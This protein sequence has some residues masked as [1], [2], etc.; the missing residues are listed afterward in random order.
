[1]VFNIIGHPEKKGLLEVA[2]PL[3]ATALSSDLNSSS[4]NNSIANCCN[5]GIALA[6]LEWKVMLHVHQVNWLVP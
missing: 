2:P 4:I 3:A 5:L 1:M 6:L